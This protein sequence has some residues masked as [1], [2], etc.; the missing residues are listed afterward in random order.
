M[1]KINELTTLQP[2]AV[3]NIICFEKIESGNNL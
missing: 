3:S 2:A 1:I